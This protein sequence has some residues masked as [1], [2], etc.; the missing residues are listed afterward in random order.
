MDSI[1]NIS[2]GGG[3]VVLTV[4]F[5][6]LILREIKKATIAAGWAPERQSRLYRRVLFALAG[7]GVFASVLALSGFLSNF[8]TFPPRMVIV[9]GIP[10][11]TLIAVTFS[12]TARE[13]LPHVPAVSLVKYQ[14]FRVFV[15]ILLWM[16]FIQNLIP[17]QMS[18]EGRNFDVF[19][20]LLAVVVTLW[21]STNRR[22]IFWYNVVSLGLLIN[23]VSIAV[24]SLPT[25]FRVFMNEPSSAIAATFPFVW[26][27][28]F[29][30]PLAYGLHFLSLRQISASRE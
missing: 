12:K 28:A 11:V 13:L 22:V 27:P 5:Y 14:V 24:L 9:I 1:I 15:E 20:G 23:I 17:Q 4:V 10:L 6:S 25:P 30:V 7:W 2:I 16:A 3:M 26:L 29:L 19:S 21:F 18:F 8:D